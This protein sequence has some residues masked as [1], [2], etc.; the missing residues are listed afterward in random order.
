LLLGECVNANWIS[1][2]EERF[3]QLLEESRQHVLALTAEKQVWQ[4]ER[5]KL[6]AVAEDVKGKLMQARLITPITLVTLITLITLN[7][8]THNQK[9]RWYWCITVMFF[10]GG[11][12]AARA[13]TQKQCNAASR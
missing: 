10:A 1:L 13:G 9:Q 3:A 2:Q 7:A 11:T 8:G 5:T 4:Q 12:M 6:L